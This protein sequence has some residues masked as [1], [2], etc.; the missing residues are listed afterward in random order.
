MTIIYSTLL[1]LIFHV[2]NKKKNTDRLAIRISQILFIE[3]NKK[4]GRQA[5]S[6]AA[7]SFNYV[8]P[9]SHHG[10]ASSVPVTPPSATA[11]IGTGG[12]RCRLKFPNQEKNVVCGGIN[13]RGTQCDFN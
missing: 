9:K 10:T 8:F 11:S 13:N 12:V 4:K 3:F 1:T 7:N 6:I 2:T 5:K